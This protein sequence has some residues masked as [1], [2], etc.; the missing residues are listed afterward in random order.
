MSH[1]EE[2]GF[3]RLTRELLCP[4]G[5]KILEIGSYNSSEP[6][7]GNRAI[8]AGYDYT[9]VDLTEGPGVDLVAS[10]HE[11]DL[12]SSSFDVTLSTECF[13]HNPVWGETFANMYRM[14]EP[15]GIVIVTCATRGRVEHGTTRSA[16]AGSSVGTTAVGWNYY[17]NLTQADFERAFDLS[18]MFTVHRFYTVRTSHDL[19][20]FGAKSGAPR[21]AFDP[22]AI[23]RRVAELGNLRPKGLKNVARSIARVP[24]G[25]LSLI[26]PERAFQNVAVPYSR[27]IYRVGAVFG[28]AV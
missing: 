24:L 19:Y 17:R 25:L 14:T 13:E 3:V 7:G 21:P 11:V 5:G 26:L 18:R 10:G 4:A 27:V 12:P 28:I 6:N 22:G 15:G 16:L 9:G 8:F 20:F 1:P 2:L 23:E